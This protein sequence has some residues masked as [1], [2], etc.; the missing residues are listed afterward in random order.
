M[1]AHEEIRTIISAL[2]TGIGAD[3]F[4]IE[5]C[6]YGKIILMTDADIDGAHIRT[7][8]LTFFFR[9]MPDLFEKRMIYV[10]QPPLYE[11]R[12]KGQ[13]KT[14]YVLAES[15][16]HKRMIS[17]GIEGTELVIRD[18]KRKKSSKV[19]GEELSALVK[20]LADAERLIHVLTR[21]GINFADFV[22]TY[23]NEKG[24]PRYRITIQGQEEIY[25]D[26]EPYQKKLDELKAAR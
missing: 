1:L 20:N 2:G 14:E 15:Q 21:R 17:R 22:N 4:D 3:E 25:Y 8:L 11:V 18:G 13:K 5:N 9:Q 12:V 16:M 10:A 7:L 24:L 23:Y 6:R 19:T 26:R